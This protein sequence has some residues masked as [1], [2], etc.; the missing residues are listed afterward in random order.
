MST[1]GT[2]SED[3][4]GGMGHE[5]ERL[6]RSAARA[7]VD[8]DEPELV[9]ELLTFEL[10]N[11]PYAIPV[12]RVR[13][14]I[15]PRE[16]TPMPRVPDCVIGVIAM[17]GEIVQV[18]DLRVRFGL[19]LSAPSR[20]SRVIVLHGDDDRVTGVL[21]DGVREVLR[22]PEVDISP[23]TANQSGSVIELCKCGEEFISIVDLD[24]MLDFDAN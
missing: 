15:R 5:W 1:R 20:R 7:S 6:A 9:R 10:A 17:R 22:V 24:Q 4:A 8:H 12:E 2:L 13:E 11:S 16:A 14:I 21:V 3:D 19:E 23:A 18:V